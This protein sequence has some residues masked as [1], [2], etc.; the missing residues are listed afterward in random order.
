MRIESNVCLKKQR[1][2][3]PKMTQIGSDVMKIWAV[4]VASVFFF[5]GGATLYIISTAR[6]TINWFVAIIKLWWFWV[7][8]Q[9][10]DC[11]PN[12]LTMSPF[13]R[14]YSGIGL[15]ENVKERRGTTNREVKRRPSVPTLKIWPQ[16]ECGP[17]PNVM[18]AL[19]NIGRALCSTPQSLADAH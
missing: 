9:K 15:R 11:G 3:V 8:P 2:S 4:V 12:D 6:S 14:C 19:P 13:C 18:V 17:M 7:G 1:W 10:C 5:G 16:L